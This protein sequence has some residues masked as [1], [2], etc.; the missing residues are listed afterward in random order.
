MNGK[1]ILEKKFRDGKEYVL[2][3]S[4][5]AQGTYNLTGKSAGKSTVLKLVIIR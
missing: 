3:L 1:V 5:A 4:G 2:D